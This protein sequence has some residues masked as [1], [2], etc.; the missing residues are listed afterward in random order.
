MQLHIKIQNFPKMKMHTKNP[1]YS[2]FT[3]QL[4]IIINISL[5]EMILMENSKTLLKFFSFSVFDVIETFV[6]LYL[7]V[8]KDTSS[9]KL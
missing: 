5:N 9:S 4:K 1:F 2:S 8:D 7:I 3:Y 6:N